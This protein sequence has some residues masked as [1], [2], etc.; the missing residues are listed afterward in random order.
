MTTAFKS[1]AD[2]SHP[3]KKR[4]L[5]ISVFESGSTK[6]VT[7]Y[8]DDFSL[9]VGGEP[10]EEKIRLLKFHVKNTELQSRIEQLEDTAI[11]KDFDVFYTRLINMVTGNNPGPTYRK[12]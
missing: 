2:R 5:D 6:D 7:E 11:D 1:M 8:L 9:A 10:S 3:K 4:K 12:L